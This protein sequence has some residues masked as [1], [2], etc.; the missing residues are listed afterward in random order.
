M[1]L[2]AIV[3]ALALIS[4]AQATERKLFTLEK[5]M[6]S[7]NIL[8]IHTQTDDNCKFIAGDNG[9]V[10]FYWLMDGLNKKPVHPMIRSKVSERVAFAGINESRDSF[11]VKLNDL[12]EI[13]HDLEDTKIEAVAEVVNGACEVRSIV[14]LGASAKYRKM[15]LKR[16]YCQVDKNLVGVP[17][18]CKYLELSGIDADNGEALKVRFRGK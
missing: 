4:S 7:E 2:S 8:M 10:D 18:G 15:N 3:M 17:K 5:S 14:K 16:T 9:Y 1:K 11:K 6:N 12:S 13:N